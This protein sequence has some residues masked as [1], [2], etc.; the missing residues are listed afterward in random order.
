MSS[1]EGHQYEKTFGDVETFCVFIGYPR[2]G[3]SLIGSLLDAHP[4]AVIAHELDALRFVQRGFSKEQIFLLALKNSQRLAKV[5]RRWEK[6][7]Y[8]VP[9]QWQG[10]FERLQVIGDKKGGSS[11]VTFAADPDVLGRLR[12][13]IDTEIKFIHVLRNPYDN[14]SAIFERRRRRNHNLGLGS[15]VDSYFSLCTTNANVK[16]QVGD[17]AVFEMRHET[18]IEDTKLSLKNLCGFLGLEYKED[19]L[20]DCARLVFDSPHKSRYDVEWQPEEITA[21][22]ERLAGYSFLEGYSYTD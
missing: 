3:H 22:G 4:N 8:E 1:H 16:D 2:S 21:V 18:L 11:T 17:A 10:R 14:I 6:Y 9:N 5:G 15:I 19:Y 20:T 7:K 13:T 12:S